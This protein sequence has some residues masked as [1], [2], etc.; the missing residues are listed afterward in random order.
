MAVSRWRI[1]R[2]LSAFILLASIIISGVCWQYD[3]LIHQQQHVHSSAIVI[4]SGSS[5]EQIAMQLQTKKIIT[6]AHIFRLYARWQQQQ[7]KIKAGEYLFDGDLSMIQVL[8]ILVS[9][10]V[11]QYHVTIAE[12]LR[13]AQVLASLAR[14]TNSPIKDWQTAMDSLL[15]DAQEGYLLPE[16]YNYVKPIKPLIV[17]QQMMQAQQAIIDGLHVQNPLQ[18]RIMASIIEKETAVLA[19]RPIIASV[20]KN[21]LKKGMPLQMDP[22]VIYGL[23]RTQGSFSGN[24]HHSDLKR[25]TPWNSYTRTGLPASPICNPSRSSLR[26]AAYPLDTQFLFFVANGKGGHTFAR[27]HK[28]HQRNVRRW[29]R[30]Q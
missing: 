20:I 17:L 25:D 9:G 22:T 26:A 21:R 28:Q 16:T 8:Q 30:G 13:T 3:R 5:L 12:G 19:E 15:G 7:S 18:V 1:I 10:K 27:S 14:Q 11:T 4:A 24:I 6:S 29:L 2:Y 23:W